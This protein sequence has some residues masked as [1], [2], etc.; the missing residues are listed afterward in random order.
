MKVVAFVIS[1]VIFLAS[2]Y[3]LGAAFEVPSDV[4]KLF[5]FVAGLVGVALSYFIPVHILKRIAP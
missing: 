3:A 4:G 2:L 5:T 1:I